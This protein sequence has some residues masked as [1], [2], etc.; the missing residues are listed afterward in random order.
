[1]DSSFQELIIKP[2]F[3]VIIRLRSQCREQEDFLSYPFSSFYSSKALTVKHQEDFSCV[4][5]DHVYD[6]FH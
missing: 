4:F 6:E 1:M 3:N 5:K 2:I